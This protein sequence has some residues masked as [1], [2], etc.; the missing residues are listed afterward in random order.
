MQNVRDKGRIKTVNLLK[1]HRLLNYRVFTV[2]TTAGW[3]RRDR[4]RQV[5]ILQRPDR[6]FNATRGAQS[7]NQHQYIFQYFHFFNGFVV[8]HHQLDPSKTKRYPPG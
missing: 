1:A 2:L 5:L 7:N 4:N 8:E 3:W 6:L